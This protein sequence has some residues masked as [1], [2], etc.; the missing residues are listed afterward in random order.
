MTEPLP[1]AS[2]GMPAESTPLL[3]PATPH[4]IRIATAL[5][6]A[7]APAI[8]T[9]RPT[10]RR[11]Q[12]YE[13][14]DAQ[15]HVQG[16]DAADGGGRHPGQQQEP[17]MAGP[18]LL[19]TVIISLAVAMATGAVGYFSVQRIRRRQHRL[20]EEYGAEMVRAIRYVQNR[21]VDGV[22]RDLLE[23]ELAEVTR[24]YRRRVLPWT[25]RARLL[26]SFF[27]HLANDTKMSLT[28]VEA[29]RLA[30]RLLRCSDAETV[31]VLNAL[32]A[33]PPRKPAGT[34]L[35]KLLF[36]AERMPLDRSSLRI[37]DKM[38]YGPEVVDS[39]LSSMA[40][41]CYRDMIEA[42]QAALLKEK[43][44][45]SATTAAN[46][47]GAYGRRHISL[48]TEPRLQQ[49]VP[50]SDEEAQL[51][52]ALAQSE[53]LLPGYADLGLSEEAARKLVQAATDAKRQIHTEAVQAL[54]IKRRMS[55]Q[56]LQDMLRDASEGKQRPSNDRESGD[57]GKGAV[58][59]R[60]ECQRCGYTI[61]PAVGREWK[62]YGDDFV[63]PQCQAPKSQFKD[64]SESNP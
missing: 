29:A 11:Y 1:A 14:S 44:G 37:R 2:D 46:I 42:K 6:L 53:P 55:V 64:V 9:R 24:V 18:S 8:D 25:P 59:H 28:C 56:Q 32:A 7:T 33:S 16:M 30:P 31:A 45:R 51:A 34:L 61:F 35:S 5:P 36:V 10:R 43:R 60:Y 50:L 41:T 62:F 58:R 4:R 12:R 3:S 52:E 22:R 19:A 40:E 39:L 63:C 17:N 48:L 26:S 20:V 15:R 57:E 23:T 47:Y 54:A 38:G 13:R 21:S 49:L 27:F